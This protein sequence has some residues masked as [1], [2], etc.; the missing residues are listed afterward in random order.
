M[1]WVKF[2]VQHTIRDQKIDQSLYQQL[3]QL[4][5]HLEYHLLGNHLLENGFA[6]FFGAYYFQDITF[7]QKAKEIVYHELEEQILQDGVH[8]E[9]SPMY[10]QWM[11]YRLLD[12]A[13]LMQQQNVFQDDMSMYISEKASKMLT[14]LQQLTFSN[15]D[16]A[17]LNDSAF[18]I[19]PT[20]TQ[21][22]SYATQLG[23]QSEASTLKES[24]YRRINKGRYELLIDVGEIG[25]SYLPGHA[26]SDMLSFILHVDSQPFLIDTGTSTYEANA[27][28]QKERSTSAHNTVVVDGAEQSEMW[29]AFRVARR[30]TV[31]KLEEGESWIKATHDGYKRKGIYHTR[32]F[33]WTE[34]ELII[35]D[36]IESKK[37]HQ[38]VAYFHFAP[39]CF[40]QVDE[41]QIESQLGN[42]TFESNNIKKIVRTN[43]DYAY[44][45]NKTTQAVQT[46]VFFQDYL[47]TRIIL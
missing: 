47:E 12:C 19:A 20:N 15:G 35:K 18:H 42:I 2:L 44:T 27:T 38:S 34:K 23:I 39:G 41:Q 24:G 25:P 30:A 40:V 32:Q 13:N 43:Y 4:L 37:N 17:L 33:E 14:A 9:L 11:L 45:F 3:H 36:W 31:V 28:R 7:Y 29:S 8:F 10:H 1:N 46:Q 26:H 5:D 6:L 16:I 21:L 22:T